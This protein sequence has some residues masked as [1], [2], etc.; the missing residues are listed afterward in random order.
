MT[1]SSETLACPTWFSTLSERLSTAGDDFIGAASD[2]LEIL[3][4]TLGA[5]EASLWLDSGGTLVCTVVAGEQQL[6]PE[7]VAGAIEGANV[8]RTVAIPLRR[9]DGGWVGAIC[10]RLE[11]PPRQE[12]ETVTAAI[13]NLVLAYY[14]WTE[15]S[16]KLREELER[17]ARLTE[18]ARQ[19]TERIIDSLPIGLYVVD[20][21]YRVCAWNRNRETGYQGVARG[22]ALGKS[23]FDVLHR[24]PR[25]LL[26][27][28]F[29]E[30]FRTGQIKQF[31]IE[32]IHDGQYRRYRISKI[33][34][35]GEGGEVTHVVT[36]GEDITEWSRAQ[37]E[38][39]HAEKLAAIGQLAAG[40]MH[41]INN[42]LATIGACAEGLAL[43]FHDLALAG[44][45]VPAQAHEYT[46]I[47]QNEVQR[48][49]QIVDSLLDFSRP[50]AS[51]REEVDINAVVERTLFLLKHHGRFKGVK[52]DK[53][54]DS[55]LPTVSG[56][57]QQL[58]QV[59]MALLLNAADALGERGAVTVRTRP[60]IS[61]ADAV[62]AE[63]IDT[64]H[65]IPREALGRIFE[66][67]YTTKPPGRGT[68]LGLA[69]SYAIVA[70]HGGRIEVESDLGAGSTF[71]VVFPAATKSREPADD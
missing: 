67:F 14:R 57:E 29:D 8:P 65:G 5:A 59:F 35:F 6:T 18:A 21:H 27:E 47:V 28:E 38:F 19:F 39:A 2:S 12:D 23:I 24:Q 25:G 10:V 4:S 36:I 53:L 30:V 31:S 1:G 11:R 54:L 70:D 37:E 50:R 52:V 49:K 26:Q 44:C 3:R 60:G 41:E 13:A 69:I 71:R 34:M 45:R 17:Q 64:G 61:D 20:R 68:G 22:D 33:P 16:H 63:V 56:D 40:V 58:V 42:P 55:H 66:P 51:K 32:S 9:S 46:E 15:R 43:T 62:I 48:C 7:D